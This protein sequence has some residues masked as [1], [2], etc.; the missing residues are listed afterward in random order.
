MS[1]TPSADAVSAP[2]PSKHRAGVL[3][4][5]LAL[6]MSMFVSMLAATVVSTSLPVIIADL[7]GDQSAFTWVVTATLLATTVSTPGHR[8][9]GVVLT[10][11]IPAAPRDLEDPNQAVVGVPGLHRAPA[12]SFVAP[13]GD[14]TAAGS[15]SWM[16][17]VGLIAQPVGA[18][19]SGHR[20]EGLA[21]GQLVA[22][23]PAARRR[24][25]SAEDQLKVSPARLV[26]HEHTNRRHLAFRGRHRSVRSSGTGRSAGSRAPTGATGSPSAGQIQTAT[27]SRTVASI[28]WV[29]GCRGQR[30]QF[31]GA[32][33]QS[34]SI[35]HSW[36]LSA[37]SATR[38][39]D[40]SLRRTKTP[41]SPPDGL[42]SVPD[43]QSG[44][45]V[46]SES[47]IRGCGPPVAARSRS[48]GSRAVRRISS[49]ASFCPRPSIR[50]TPGQR[51]RGWAVR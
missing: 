13:I 20:A 27:S 45:S 51:A 10:I 14:Q 28:G 38:S 36:T 18:V 48:T 22:L 43:N 42:H 34:S 39:I 30:G 26:G 8:P 3:P 35:T 25:T 49:T 15:R 31:V 4:V 24:T 5:M 40:E 47:S 44:S 11:L 29:S 6:M 37:A 50:L 41:L 12:D 16:P 21:S 46:Q 7:G 2:T 23:A 17:G 9:D 19:L 1:V 33:D 32:R